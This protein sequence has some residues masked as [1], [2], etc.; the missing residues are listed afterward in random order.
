MR[1]ERRPGQKEERYTH[2][3]GDDLEDTPAPAAAPAIAQPQAAP[4]A[5]DRVAALE[6]RVEALEREVAELRQAARGGS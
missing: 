2:L 1:L 5:G 6:R 3:L 4:P